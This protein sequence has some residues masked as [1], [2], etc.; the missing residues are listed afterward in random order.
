M[1]KPTNKPEWGAAGVEPS[2]NKKSQG[3]AAGEKPSAAQMNWLFKTVSEW[4][5]HVDADQVKGDTGDAGPQ[6]EKGVIGDTGAQGAQG[7]KGDTGDAGLQGEQGLKGETGD[8]GLPGLKGETGDTGPQ[9][10]KGLTGDQGPQGATGS[11]ALDATTEARIAALENKARISTPSSVSAGVPYVAG[12]ASEYDNGNSGATKTIDWSNGGS[13]KLTLSANC[14]VSFAN[15]VSGGI[16]FLK[17]TQGTVVRTITWPNGIT[18]DA[19]SAPAAPSVACSVA[20][21]AF[22]YDGSNYIGYVKK[23]FTPSV[24]NTFA[25][26]IIA[27]ESKKG[28]VAGGVTGGVS[29]GSAITSIQKIDFNVDTIITT[30]QSQFS[31]R[32]NTTGEYASQ[33]SS[34]HTSNGQGTQSSTHGYC[35]YQLYSALPTVNGNNNMCV[36]KMAFATDSGQVTTIRPSSSSLWYGATRRSIVQSA[37]NAYKH[38]NATTFAKMAFSTDA[39]STVTIGSGFVNF[40]GYSVGMSTDS[41]GYTWGVSG[42]TGAGYKLAFTTETAS[43]ASTTTSYQ[44]YGSGSGW[45][46][47]VDGNT[48]GYVQLTISSLS[49]GTVRCYKMLKSTDVWSTLV[50][51]LTGAGAGASATQGN[52]CGYFCGG[53][54]ATTVGVTT[55]GQN[56]I[57]RI[58]MA[59]DAYAVSGTTLAQTQAFAAGFEG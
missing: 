42:S 29:G 22:Y 17:L 37:D 28:Y 36:T 54:N 53:Q 34:S 31:S 7:V 13:Q 39:F 27:L 11:A 46:E 25:I 38:N 23:T 59:S 49:S 47:A 48:A 26:P 41:I 30:V 14:V 5:E 16:Y 43:I 35:D 8:Q 44:A 51:S 1:S 19:G 33:Q 4:I 3:W 40:A 50:T 9:G 2:S 32:F 6:G 45:G 18:W 15:P 57:K 12:V 56:T 10:P 24:S 58:I 21:L 52:A 20:L 55:V